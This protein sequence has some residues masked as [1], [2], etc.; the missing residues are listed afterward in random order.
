MA[1]ISRLKIKNLF[2]IK[3]FEYNG[4]S[5]ELF[6]ENGTGKTSVIDAIRFALTNKS[7]RK[8]LISN[9]A[10][11]GEV[12]V[13]MDN[14]VMIDRKPRT[15]RADYK[16]I[17]V[18]GDKGEKTETF[19]REIFNELQLNPVEF[20]GMTEKEQNRII[21][22]LIDFKWDLNW[23]KEQFGEIVPDVNYEQNILCVLHDIQA[24][25]GYYFLKRQDINR[26][27][28][29]KSAFINEIGNTLP[30]GYVASKWESLNLAELYKKIESIRN[31][32]QQ[33]EK[34]KAAIQGRDNKI[35]G[36]QA[37]FEI[38]KGAIEKEATGSRNSLEK[39]VADLE[40]KIRECKIQLENL[41]QKKIDRLA[42]AKKTFEANV[43]EFE[44]EVKQYED[45][46]KQEIE[47]FAELQQEAEY[48]EKMKSHINEYKRMVELQVQ[49]EKLN[50]QSEDLT[51]KIERARE[52]PGKILEISKVP[53]D[54]LT[55]KDGVPLINGLPI[56]NLSE[57]EKF[58]LCI[59][60]AT[61]NPN[62]LQMVLIDGI[63]R[64]ATGKREQVYKELK[65]KG[66][67]FI[68]TRT[69]DDHDL[70]VIEL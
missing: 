4:K 20:A 25:D 49:V 56:S 13:E 33:I 17:K 34:A 32:N 7:D 54:G 21:L 9:G 42:I 45:V 14:G 70:N 19:L 24:E 52:L 38:E 58:E 55:I 31:K 69:T 47:P 8:F 39:M 5:I 44:G 35:R 2:G 23:I 26:E 62:G 1:K 15:N 10:S 16:S 22:D 50:Q 63:E 43:A 53:I 37:D 61:K 28:R 29:H 65:E 64:L 6:G 67:Q 27:S 41:E 40:A 60:V 68:A 46:A 18:N 36:F 3:E 57:G 12:L 11:E 66:V 30:A 59:K 48:I 51:A